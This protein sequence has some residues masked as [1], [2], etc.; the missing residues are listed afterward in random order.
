[1]T[2]AENLAFMQRYRR[3]L[4]GDI[5]DANN[6]IKRT[7]DDGNVP[8]TCDGVLRLHFSLFISFLFARV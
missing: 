8:T 7:N 4:V 3:P 6:V 1:M 2:V 5:I